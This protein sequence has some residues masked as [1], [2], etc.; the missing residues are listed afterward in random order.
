MTTIINDITDFSDPNSS[1]SNLSADSTLL[2][3]SSTDNSSVGKANFNLTLILNNIYKLL[4]QM[5]G[6]MQNVTAVQAQRLNILTQW[7][8]AYTEALAKVHTFTSADNISLQVPT[9]ITGSA[10]NLAALNQYTSNLITTLQGNRSAVSDDSKSLQSSVNSSNDAVTQQANLATSFLQELT[11][12][13]QAIY[14]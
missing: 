11:T 5:I 7:Q 13:L 8:A 6:V 9:G 10:S 1:S 2:T 14:R 4:T 3:L 12:L